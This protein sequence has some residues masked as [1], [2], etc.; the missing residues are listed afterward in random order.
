MRHSEEHLDNGCHDCHELFTM[1]SLG[2]CE[3]CGGTTEQ[4][5]LVLFLDT[6]AFHNSQIADNYG[7]F[8]LLIGNYSSFHLPAHPTALL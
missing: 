6:G 4:R 7:F 8:L 3:E 2:R 5:Y 1:A